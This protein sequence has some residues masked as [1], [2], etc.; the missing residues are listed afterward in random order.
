MSGWISSAKEVVR[1]FLPQIPA[2]TRIGVRVF[3]ADSYPTQPPKTWG[4]SF[5]TVFLTSV[6]TSG[7]QNS[8]QI[9]PLNNTNRSA[10]MNALNNTTIGGGTPLVFALRQTFQSDLASVYANRKKIILLTDG[11]DT[12]GEDPCRYIRSVLAKRPDVQIDVVMF[13]NSNILQCLSEATNGKYY[14]VTNKNQ[15]NNIMGASFGVL[16][17]SAAYEYENHSSGGG[18]SS[19]KSSY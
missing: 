9:V 7:C 4:E 12:C 19:G 13:G 17:E 8:K 5:K 11:G 10:I 15:L 2:S 1:T 14:N 18:M 3:G 6:N 16:P